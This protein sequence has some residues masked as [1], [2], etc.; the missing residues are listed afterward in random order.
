MPEKQQ[1]P[2]ETPYRGTFARVECTDC[3]NEQI[4]FNRAA[5]A[6]TC[7]VCGA[8]LANPTGGI[9]DLEGTFIEYVD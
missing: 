6:I 4:V 7:Q 3:G 8:G 2:I 1:V 5:K 9:V